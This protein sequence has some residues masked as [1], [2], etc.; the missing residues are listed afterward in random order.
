MGL[1]RQSGFRLHEYEVNPVDN[2]VAGPNGKRIVRPLSMQVLLAIVEADGEFISLREIAE[3]VS[4]GSTGNAEKYAACVREWR[5]F[6][7]DTQAENRF[8]DV[9]ADHG[10]RLVAPLVLLNDYI[11]ETDSGPIHVTPLE[12][13]NTGDFLLQ[14]SSGPVVLHPVA[15]GEV[16][17]DLDLFSELKRRRVFRA[18]GA[19]AVVAW[20]LLQIVDVLSGALP[21]PDWTL[22]A[23]T[24]A[25]GV[26][27]PIAAVVAWIFQ[28]TPQGLVQEA[29]FGRAD[30]SIDRA[31]LVHYFDLVIIA[32]LLVVV[33]FLTYGRVFPV[34]GS[35][36][37][38]TVAVLPFES[39]SKAA[40]DDYLADGI[41]DDIRT[42][43]YD[44]PQFLVAARTSS[45][46]LARKGMDVKSMGE[47][48]GVAHILEG[49]VRRIDDR[50]RV[51]VELVDVDS[52]FSR[53]NN[54]Y[55]TDSDAVQRLQSRISLVVASELKVLLT[56]EVRQLLAQTATDDPVA[57]DLYLQ[58]RSYLDR[59]RTLENLQQASDHF[60]EAI[61]QDNA[62]GLGYAG[63]C[64]SDTAFF[65]FTSDPAH[66][67]RA[68][69]NCNAAL[70]LNAEPSVVHLALGNLYLLSGRLDDAQ[71]SF[72]RVIALDAKA[73]DA[74]TGLG[75]VLAKQKNIEAA[76]AQFLQ[77]IG[78]R[79]ANWFGYNE[80]GRFLL[81]QGRYDESIDNFQQAI[82]LA[83]DNPHGYNNLGV[84]YYFLGDFERAAESYRQSLELEPGRGAY[85]NLGSLYYYAGNFP[86]AASMFEKAV[87][88]T[89]ADYRLWGNLADAQRFAEK[90]VDNGKAAYETAVELVKRQL[91]LNPNDAGAHTALAWYLANLANRDGALKALDAASALPSTGVNQYYTAAITYALLGATADAEQSINQARFLG[92]SQAI[93]DATPE[94]RDISDI[95]E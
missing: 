94:L 27:F 17:D 16:V 48:L 26:G 8:I 9:D 74:H 50:I 61:A 21:V 10:Y 66:I 33:V 34:L 86:E 36:E 57:Y 30:I 25:L 89:P 2:T 78:L 11:F 44:I 37:E 13:S 92:L 42:R 62:F 60:K 51:H 45:R 58:A 31:R 23:T 71:A 83:P 12:G 41:A 24:V 1:T 53:W 76:E 40:G 54:T 6:L 5:E 70:A 79:P 28:I 81:E 95:P 52:G 35:D 18:I 32:I 19:Y 88:E 68:E 39:Q 77:A 38:V 55:D 49:T 46:S 56:R 80:Y 59:P 75:D 85:S 43:L 14:T 69:V 91:D 64:Q 67:E 82:V 15:D 90:A 29:D 20:L 7:G 47:R 22:T 72:S 63:L 93:I 65:R 87:E 3:A 4:P 73:A 84:N